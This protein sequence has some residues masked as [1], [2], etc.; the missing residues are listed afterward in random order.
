MVNKSCS[1]FAG[2]NDL[3]GV[4]SVGI[5]NSEILNDISEVEVLEKI[6]SVGIDGVASDKLVNNTL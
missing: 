4:L 1:L 3:D 2:N 5:G 6:L